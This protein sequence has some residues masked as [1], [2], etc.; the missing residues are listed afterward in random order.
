MVFTLG[1]CDCCSEMAQLE[2]RVCPSCVATYG[3]RMALLIG[4]A[5]V[6]AAFADA[7]A[8]RMSAEARES[9]LRFLHKPAVTAQGSLR[10]TTARSSSAQ[11]SGRAHLHSIGGRK[12]S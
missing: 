1:R 5:R 7:C 3:E 4:R 11:T 10:K 12:R 8:A 2:L 6:D 9:F